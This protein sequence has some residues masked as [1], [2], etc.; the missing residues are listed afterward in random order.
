MKLLFLCA[1]TALATPDRAPT[2]ELNLATTHFGDHKATAGWKYPGE[3][4]AHPHGEWYG[5]YSANKPRARR[6]TAKSSDS[7][8][9]AEPACRAWD[10]HDKDRAGQMGKG[11]ARRRR[12]AL[13][14]RSARTCTSRRASTGPSGRRS[15]RRRRPC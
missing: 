10:W 2:I 1:A 8:T 11:D 4:A 6:C 7:T 13:T 12:V 14:R 15:R 5:D 9:C 3:D